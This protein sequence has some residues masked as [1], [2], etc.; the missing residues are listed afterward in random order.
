MVILCGRL[1]D[2]VSATIMVPSCLILQIIVMLAYMGIGD[3]TGW[4]AYALAVFQG[5][6][7]YNTIVSMQGYVSKRTPKMIRGMI[8]AIIG[9]LNA[10]GAIVY[11]Q[12][13]NYLFFKLG[14]NWVF[15]AL[16]MLDCF[17]LFVLLVAILFGKYGEETD[18]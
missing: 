3:P 8:F 12:L 16:A 5:G 6:T 13:A 11:L 17:M 10:L 4:P 7:G 9:I 15:A 1:T 14:P 2:K 18:V